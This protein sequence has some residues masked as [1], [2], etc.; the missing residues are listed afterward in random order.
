MGFGGISPLS[1][2]LI[3]VIILVLFGAKRLKTIGH[4]LGSALKSFRSGLDEEKETLSKNNNND[5]K[6][7]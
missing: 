3:L 5:E 4:D 6:P 2:I 1:L 7:S